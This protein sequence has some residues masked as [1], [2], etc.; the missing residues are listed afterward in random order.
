MLKLLHMTCKIGIAL[1]TIGCAICISIMMLHTVSAATHHAPT[2]WT[3]GVVTFMNFLV[4]GSFWFF[5][6][7]SMVA[8]AYIT[9]PQAWL[10]S[11]GHPFAEFT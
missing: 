11:K 3:A 9:R 2:T 4:M 5:P 10:N 7:I 1:W 6:T 8:L